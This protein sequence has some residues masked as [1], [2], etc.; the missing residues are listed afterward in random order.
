MVKGEEVF[1]ITGFY[2]FGSMDMVI[3]PVLQIMPVN[4]N[5]DDSTN[6]PYK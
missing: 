6:F 5:L 3:I 4:D 1:E 2:L